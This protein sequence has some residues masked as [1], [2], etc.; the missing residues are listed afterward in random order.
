MSQRIW[1]LLIVVVAVVLI[2]VYIVLPNSPGINVGGI[3]KQFVTRLGLDLVGGVQALLE[4]DVPAGTPIEPGAMTAAVGV[5]ENRVNGLGLNEAVVQGVG[6]NRIVVELPGEKDPEKAL[7]TIQQT[8]LLEFVDMSAI[9]QEEASQ[10]VGSTIQTYPMGGTPPAAPI[11]QTEGV[12]ATAVTP[13]FPVVM[14]GADLESVQVEKSQA[15]NDYLINFVLTSKGAQV[16][17]EFTATH[18]GKVLAIV[19]DKQ[20]LNVPAI[21]SQIPNGQGQISGGFTYEEANALAIQLRYGSLPI[22][23]KV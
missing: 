15:G 19:I 18:I 13:A 21:Q 16:F 6:N 9:S 20:V 8:G 23:L 12:T 14:T 4:A 10:L 1:K 17:S 22:P 5:V 2:S 11:T 3:E 7:A